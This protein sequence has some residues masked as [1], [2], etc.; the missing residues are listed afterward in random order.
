MNKRSFLQIIAVILILLI[1]HAQ[2]AKTQKPPFLD[3]N[4]AIIGK[5]TL[6]QKIGQLFMVAAVADEQASQPIMERKQ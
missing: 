2:Q 4:T 6:E 1:P 3:K 5:L